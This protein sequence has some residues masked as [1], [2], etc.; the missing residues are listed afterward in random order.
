ME[1]L[2]RNLFTENKNN[3][4]MNILDINL[5]PEKIHCLLKIFN[6]F[7]IEAELEIFQWQFCLS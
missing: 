3:K 2:P 6:M 5:K 4:Y 7:E 1:S